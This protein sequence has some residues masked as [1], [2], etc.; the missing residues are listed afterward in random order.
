MAKC[1]LIFIDE[2]LNAE[3]HAMHSRKITCLYS[4][5]SG[6]PN[7]RVKPGSNRRG[8]EEEARI[9]TCISVSRHQGRYYPS[10]PGIDRGEL[11]E[12]DDQFAVW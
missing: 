11:F 6:A 2:Y 3:K 7:W 4:K 12:N 10:I 1:P 8:D 5:R 9:V